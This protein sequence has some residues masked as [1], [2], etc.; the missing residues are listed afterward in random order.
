MLKNHKLAK[1]IQELGLYELRR[2]LEYKSLWYRRELV[3]VS[4]WYPSSKTCCE[5]GWKNDNLTLGDREFMCEDCGNV[6]DR[7]LNASINIKNEGLRILE[8][9]IRQ[10]LPESFG[11]S[12]ATLEDNPTM[13]DKDVNPLKSSGWMIQ[14]DV[15]LNV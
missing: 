4:R 14:E 8:E 10:R 1:S 3:F 12:Q 13:D 2:Q 9:K 7:D 5:C 6:I 11:V 15:N